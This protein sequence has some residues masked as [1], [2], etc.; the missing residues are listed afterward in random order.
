MR[1][2]QLNSMTETEQAELVEELHINLAT[3]ETAEEGLE[4]YY[5]ECNDWYISIEDEI[6][7]QIYYGNW[8]DGANQMLEH[9]L[10]VHNLIDW[11]EEQEEEGIDYSW[12]DRG[13]A[14]SMEIS[15]QQVRREAA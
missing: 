2:D 10:S 8:M 14:V 9:G 11:I 7:S 13:S 15:L 5:R 4:Q 1:A 12:F 3:N 6:L